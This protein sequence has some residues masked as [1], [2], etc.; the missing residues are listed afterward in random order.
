MINWRHRRE[1][2]ENRDKVKCPHC[3]YTMPIEYT[4]EATASGLFVKCKGRQCG[5]VFEIKLPKAN[6]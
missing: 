1:M 5:K 3:G 4:R 6:K 2:D